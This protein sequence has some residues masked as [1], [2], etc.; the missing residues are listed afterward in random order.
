MLSEFSSEGGWGVRY[1]C[2]V[3]FVNE[4]RGA[5]ALR[6]DNGMV[7]RFEGG[8][9]TNQSNNL[10]LSTCHELIKSSFTRGTLER[11]KVVRVRVIFFCF[12]FLLFCSCVCCQNQYIYIYIYIYM[13]STVFFFF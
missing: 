7:T 4:V 10:W 6:E 5:R 11:R 13:F 2:A 12:L 8:V 1:A 9:T 3:V